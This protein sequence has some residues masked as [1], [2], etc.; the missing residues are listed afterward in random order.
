MKELNDLATLAIASRMKQMSDKIF[1]AG[2]MIYKKNNINFQANWFPF[3]HLMRNGDLYTITEISEKLG[4]SHSAISQFTKKVEKEN[5]LK[6]VVD[7]SDERKRYITLSKKGKELI[8]T[9]EPVWVDLMQTMKT[10]ISDSENNIVHAM[11]TFENI[12]T[13]E[14]FVL[15]YEN[16]VRQKKENTVEIIEYKK[17]YKEDFKR[18]NYEWLEKFFYVE[19]ID[20]KVLSDPE[21]IIIKNGGYIY[22]AIYNDTIIGTCALIKE[23]DEKYELSKMAVTEE[24]QGLKAGKRLAEA[25]INKFKSLNSKTLFLETNSKLLTAIRLYEKLGFK[26]LRK[27]E[28]SHYKRADVYMVYKKV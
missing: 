26:K 15:E 18:L 7:K 4:Q 5:L 20:S 24:F 2:D 21:N 13:P 23:S 16:R 27:P 11:D 19:E 3:F 22:F 9:L 12:F 25:I 17:E 10:M 8:K 28:G 1:L 14:E 6:T